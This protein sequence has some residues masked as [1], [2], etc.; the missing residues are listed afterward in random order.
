MALKYRLIQRVNPNLPAEPR[1][2]YAHVVTKGEITIRELAEEI[3]EISTVSSVDTLAVIESFTRLI[4]KHLSRGVMVRLGDFG[5]YSIGILSQGADTEEEFSERL[6]KGAKI[7]FRPGREVK[8]AL[9][10][11]E[12]EKER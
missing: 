1:K 2:F 10:A 8:K 6:I 5:S 4:P 3:A 11:I 7:Y 12:F 9:S